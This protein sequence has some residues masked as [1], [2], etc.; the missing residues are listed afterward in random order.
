M[1]N[2]WYVMDLREGVS[3]CAALVEGGLDTWLLDWGI[4]EDEDRYR[5][6]DD[7]VDRIAD[8]LTGIELDADALTAAVEAATTRFGVEMPGVAPA[9]LA[10]AI[11]AAVETGD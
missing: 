3:L 4:P 6:W 9:D 8:A 1:I 5:T 11:M 10:G 2:R 7:G